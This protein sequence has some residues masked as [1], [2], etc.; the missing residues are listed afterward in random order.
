MPHSVRTSEVAWLSSLLKRRIVEHPVSK[1]LPKKRPGDV[2]G[3]FDGYCNSLEIK[4]RL[5]LLQLKTV[6]KKGPF[7]IQIPFYRHALVR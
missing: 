7:S 5:A 6:P 3:E 2:N 1:Q 4:L